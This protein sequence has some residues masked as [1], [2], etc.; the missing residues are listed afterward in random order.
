M[1]KPK[2]P[3]PARLFMS[4]MAAEETALHQA[5]KDLEQAFGKVDFVS[6]RFPFNQTDYYTE[7]MGD[8]LFRHFVTFDGL[9]PPSSLPE[10]KRSTNRIEEKCATREG[11]RQINIDPGYLCLEH[12]I[13]ATTKGYSHRPYLRDGIYADLALI[14][15]NKSF[16]P[17]EWTYPDYRQPEVI[18]LFNELRKTYFEAL[19]RRSL[20]LC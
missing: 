1:G 20:H 10:V 6:E 5:L 17:L 16:E 13:L 14:Y 8:P 11:K 9:I 3:N 4:L 2:E 19:K 15:R 18:S 12:L 7:E